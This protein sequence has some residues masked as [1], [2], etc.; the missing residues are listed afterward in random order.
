M[1]TSLVVVEEQETFN[2]ATLRLNGI[3]CLIF[4]A[5]APYQE[6]YRSRAARIDRGEAAVA[7]SHYLK[8]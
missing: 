4:D 6:F 8:N 5:P 7:L 2:A 1:T 3:V